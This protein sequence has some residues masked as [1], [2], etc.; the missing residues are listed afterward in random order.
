LCYTG[1]AVDIYGYSSDGNPPTVYLTLDGSSYS[2]D[3]KQNFGTN[4]QYYSHG[5]PEDLWGCSIDYSIVSSPNF[6]V[7]IDT[8][9]PDYNVFVDHVRMKIYYSGIANTGPQNGTVF[10]GSNWIHPE[11]VETSNDS[12]AIYTTDARQDV[13]VANG[14][15][16]GIPKSATILGIRVAVEASQRVG[17]D[18]YLEVN[19]ARVGDTPAGSYV[20]SD[21]LTNA[22]AYY[23]FG[24]SSS[25]WDDT[26]WS[27]SNI[28]QMSVLIRT[29]V[30][31]KNEEIYVDH[32]YVIVY[33]QEAESSTTAVSVSE[34]IL[35]DINNIVNRNVALRHDVNF[36]ACRGL[37]TTW[38]ARNTASCGLS[39]TWTISGVGGAISVGFT[40]T[41][42]IWPPD[43]ISAVAS[44]T[45]NSGIRSG[46][47]YPYVRNWDTYIS[48]VSG[49]IYYT[50][51][52]ASGHGNSNCIFPA[53]RYTDS[54]SGTF[55]TGGRL[56]VQNTGIVSVRMKM[57]LL[58]EAGDHP[59][60]T[61]ETISVAPGF[62]NFINFSFEKYILPTVSSVVPVGFTADGPIRTFYNH[63]DTSSDHYWRSNYFHSFDSP[64]I[65]IEGQDI[66]GTTTFY[67]QILY[68][69]IY[70]KYYD[71][72]ISAIGATTTGIVWIRIA[73]PADPRVTTWASWYAEGPTTSGEGMPNTLLHPI[74]SKP[75]FNGINQYWLNV[76][77][78]RLKIGTTISGSD[79]YETADVGL[80]ELLSSSTSYNTRC[81]NIQYPATAVPPEDGMTYYWQLRFRSTA[82]A[83]SDWCDPQTMIGIMPTGWWD[84][85]YNRRTNIRF[86]NNHS[87][88]PSGYTVEFEFPTGY[89]E[90]M[91]HDGWSN[92][93]IQHSG[94]H[95]AYFS[96][97]CYVS[98]IGKADLPGSGV[99]Q[100]AKVAKINVST[101]Q[102]E[103]SY[104]LKTFNDSLRGDTH[105]Y[106]VCV[107]GGDQKLHVWVGGHNSQ[108][109]YYKTT[110]AHING[111]GININA[112]EPPQ[113]P[114]GLSESTYLRPFVDS[115]GRIYVFFRSG[116]SYLGNNF[117]KA[118][119]L[120][121]IYSITNGAYWSH[122]QYVAFYGDYLV[123]PPGLYIGGVFC[124]TN[125]NRV[126]ALICWQENI[127]G[128]NQK[129]RGISLIYSDQ[130][131]AYSENI[132]KYLKWYEMGG[133][134]VGTATAD[135]ITYSSV[136]WDPNT[137]N[138]CMS[139]T[140]PI[141]R[142][143]N[144]T[145]AGIVGPYYGTNS[146]ALVLDS[147]GNPSCVFYREDTGLIR[148]KVSILVAN[149]NTTYTGWCITDLS[150]MSSFCALTTGN[151]N[152][153]NVSVQNAT[154]AGKK[155]IFSGDSTTE[156]FDNCDSTYTM[157]KAVNY[158]VS[159]INN[160]NPSQLVRCTLRGDVLPDNVSNS[161]FGRQYYP[162]NYELYSRVDITASGGYK[163]WGGRYGGQ[164]IYDNGVLNSYGYCLP[165]ESG[166]EYYAGELRRWS[167]SDNGIM[168]NADWISYNSGKGLGMISTIGNVPADG[169]RYLVTCRANDIVFMDDQ[170]F[171]AML[172]NGE[173][174]RII[175][176]VRNPADL[177]S[178]TFEELDRLPDAWQLN[179]TKL[180][181]M[182]KDNVIQNYTYVSGIIYQC[183]WANYLAGSAPKNPQNVW[184]FYDNMESVRTNTSLTGVVG[185]TLTP[186]ANATVYAIDDTDNYY[187]AHAMKMWA[188]SKF[189]SIHGSGCYPYRLLSGY[190]TD[191]QFEAH[192]WIEGYENAC[193]I[194]VEDTGSGNY[195]YFGAAGDNGHAAY[196]HNTATGWTYTYTSDFPTG[197]PFHSYN[198][199]I[200]KIVVT[201]SG[202]KA[203]V[204]DVQLFDGVVNITRFNKIVIGGG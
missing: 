95:I 201:S 202:T 192:L 199:Y 116:G 88:L 187:G 142:A 62:N 81:P 148:Q 63:T 169:S 173:D 28:D 10:S 118:H 17:T 122:R 40:T 111:Q 74:I 2:G 102:V 4:P 23:R 11:N 131:L 125:T 130:E 65:D 43:P 119:S 204:N 153:Y 101:F 120:A 93:A 26:G 144:Y 161:G 177:L 25:L 60:T 163:V 27:D 66:Q 140:T 133:R 83:W 47:L 178:Y 170:D 150:H 156:T 20:S 129:P 44:T 164:L 138:V 84:N 110:G 3:S 172:S 6:G 128:A 69:D 12:H 134:L 200:L 90:T 41:W 183:Y 174:I 39:S 5:G 127:Y 117:S 31:D 99:Y 176:A 7:F 37:A 105:Y 97:Y 89:G 46:W 141:M 33:Y 126:Y 36:L 168:W 193:G 180:N 50:A 80:G 115:S 64:P 203:Y 182:V 106:P 34:T 51:P 48:I 38:D 195:F 139:G 70:K 18:D 171:P 100:C 87:T 103:D 77:R 53:S 61:S 58:D 72:N 94:K 189:V 145:V 136:G 35:Y 194:G 181:F 159:T 185:W 190:V 146:E 135:R 132:F 22:D 166:L 49:Y 68:D 151:N 13:L 75:S 45:N 184:P 155:I 113:A 42:D 85:S 121:Y 82:G 186:A 179:N 76:T 9:G 152:S 21:V 147:N 16:F 8:S 162:P 30:L 59:I 92:E 52:P 1:I 124:D 14:F 107:V 19:V 165:I 137:M 123:N 55:V 29:S 160:G 79:I 167:S 96:G 73:P 198:E 54:F 67:A 32:I 143:G 154:S 108:A 109:Y 157:W 104:T 188:G 57:F 71:C 56:Y 175:R 149:W 114:F 91:I 158:G 15:T 191:S 24:G 197:Y 98:Y 196:N 78:Y 112:F 86:G